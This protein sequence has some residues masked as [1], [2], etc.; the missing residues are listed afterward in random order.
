MPSSS[1]RS[2]SPADDCE[3]AVRALANLAMV[4]QQRDPGDPRIG[5]DLE[6]ALAY[7]REHELDG[8]LQYLL[9]A[10]AQFRLLRGNWDGA[11]DDARR[12]LATAG[13][14]PGAGAAMLVLGRLRA[15]RGDPDASVDTRR[16]GTARGRHRRAPPR[17]GGGGGARRTRVARRR[18]PR[19]RRRGPP[20]STPRARPSATHSSTP[21]SRSGSGAPARVTDRLS[22][23]AATRSR[24]PVTRGARPRRGRRWGS[25]T[26]PPMPRPTATQPRRSRRWRRSIGSARWP[27]RGACVAGF[28]TAECGGCRA[29]RDPPLAPRRPG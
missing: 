24:S 4:T 27:P 8:P 13:A 26:K 19:R 16:G 18:D 5:G 17:R 14:G 21:S 10:R 28:R 22:T 3:H 7:A 29:A 9:G 20:M 6:R 11:E 23:A 15:R 25:R 12:S 1:R 2:R